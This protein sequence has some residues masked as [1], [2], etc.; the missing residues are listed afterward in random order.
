MLVY[1][2]DSSKI[3]GRF[4]VVESHIGRPVCKFGR[5]LYSALS[6]YA[7]RRDRVQDSEEDSRDAI[8]QT[9]WMGLRRPTSL[10]H[11][12]CTILQCRISK[13]LG[14][15]TVCI[16]TQRMKTPW[17]RLGTSVTI[18]PENMRCTYGLNSSFKRMIRMRGFCN[19]L[20]PP[21]QKYQ[22]PPAFAAWYITG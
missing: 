12:S 22:R 6:H 18:T 3:A 9:L 21:A 7:E 2:Q 10:I 15:N 5:T 11:E 19:G 1:S 4:F 14:I 13:F 17:R 8:S 20:I 16:L